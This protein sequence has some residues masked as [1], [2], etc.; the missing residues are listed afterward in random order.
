MHAL[1][2]NL[3]PAQEFVNI[4]KYLPVA[5]VVTQF[6]PSKTKGAIQ[7]VHAVDD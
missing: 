5:Q 6:A 1:Q 3:H 7:S 4:S 2:G